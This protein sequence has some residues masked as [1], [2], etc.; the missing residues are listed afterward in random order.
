MPLSSVQLAVPTDVFSKIICVGINYR[1][2]A[3]ETRNEE[4]K[5]PILFTRSLDSLV[6]AGKP[7]LR[8]RCSETFD[9]KAR[10]LS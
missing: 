4:P 10:S 2:H 8:P 3:G 6:A 7:V 9:L 5:N 1:D